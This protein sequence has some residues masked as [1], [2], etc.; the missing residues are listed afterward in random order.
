MI[1]SSIAVEGERHTHQ[2]FDVV[3]FHLKFQLCAAV[4]DVFLEQHVHE[5]IDVSA[6]TLTW[7]GKGARIAHLQTVNNC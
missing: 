2:L 3:L 1:N 7:S 6:F 4:E 5:P